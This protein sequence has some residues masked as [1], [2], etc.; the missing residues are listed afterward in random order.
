MR[1]SRLRGSSGCSAVF[2]TALLLTFLSNTWAQQTSDPA[3][4]WLSGLDVYPGQMTSPITALAHAGQSAVPEMITAAQSGPSGDEV[5]AYQ[6]D[7]T[8]FY[9]KME[10]DGPVTG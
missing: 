7:T 1:C 6:A 9:I 2:T 3:Q 5:A 8:Q 10:Q 4:V